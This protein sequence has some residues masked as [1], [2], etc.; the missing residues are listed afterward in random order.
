M[1]NARSIAEDFVECLPVQD[2]HMDRFYGLC[3]EYGDD[4]ESLIRFLDVGTGADTFRE[5]LEQVTL[6]TLHA[7]KGL[8]F[9][10]VFIVGCE[11]GIIPCT[12][13]GRETN[14]DEERRLMY[15][16]MTRAK[17]LLVLNHADRRVVYGKELRL[18]RSGLVDRIL[19]QLLQQHQI[20]EFRKKKDS[21]QLDLF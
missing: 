19:D 12:L 20:P 14:P 8:E 9:R 16:G 6:M 4:L 5:G 7:A 1:E 3:E 13:F 15:V 10:G 2:E 21:G 17:E 11:E 18:P